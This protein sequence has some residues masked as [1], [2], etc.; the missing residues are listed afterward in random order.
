MKHIGLFFIL[1]CAISSVKSQSRQEVLDAYKKEIHELESLIKN[2]K[3][4]YA[5]SKWSYTKEDLLT[6]GLPSTSYIEH[7]AYY[8]EYS[9][10]HEQAK[11]VAHTIT[12]DIVDRGSGRTNDF[13]TDSLVTTGTAV[14]QDYFNYFPKRPKDEQYKGFGYDRGH[15]APAADFGWSEQ[16]VSESFYYSNM[17]PMLAKFNR[18]IWADLEQALRNYVIKHK[19][20]L[21]I[22]T[23]P[24]LSDELPIIKQSPN[25]VSI[26]EQFIKIAYDHTNQR[27][28]AFLMPNKELKKPLESYALTIDEVER[29]TDYD[30]FPSIDSKIEAAF[31]IAAWFP[32]YNDVSVL[33]IKQNTLPRG[34]YNTITATQQMG[35]YKTVKVCGKVVAAR[36]SNSGNVWI[37]LDKKFPNDFF[38][39]VIWKDNL[40]NF[41]YDPPT[42]F[43]DKEICVEGKVRDAHGKPQISL[44]SPFNVEIY[45]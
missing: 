22:I 5:A 1:F 39:A 7:L 15:L 43:L 23:A 10:E 27:A 2:F 33:P 25:R 38:S 17:S 13:R 34:C 36:Y 3:E 16:A 11:W 4:D 41:T 42:Y 40:T 37:N 9:E 24:I 21:A 29:L 26:P 30:F 8:L 44:K 19:V 45:R 12:P 35:K 14:D 6:Y 18:E 31:E 32:E 28:I 20:A